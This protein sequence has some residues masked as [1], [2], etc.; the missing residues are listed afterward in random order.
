MTHNAE[1]PYF[2]VAN[3]VHW[4]IRRLYQKI[5]S[6]RTERRVATNTSANIHE[7][8][9]KVASH[10]LANGLGSASFRIR[11]QDSSRRASEES[12]ITNLQ[13]AKKMKFNQFFM[14]Q[15]F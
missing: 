8:S 7:E 14:I 4:Q 12:I 10:F 1:K 13:K 3:P 9:I 6:K 5:L 2:D 11:H 15:P